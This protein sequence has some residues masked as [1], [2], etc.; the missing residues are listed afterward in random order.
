MPAKR[1]SPLW[2]AFTLVMMT[3]LACNLF[4][5]RPTPT[6]A[7]TPTPAVSPTP[8]P[9]IAPNIID[10]TPQRGDELAPNGAI[11]VYFDSPM[12]RSSVE[13]AFA[14]A[15]QVTGKFDWPDDSTL[16]FTPANPLE[17]ASRYTVTINADAKSRAGLTLPEAF[18]FKADTVGFLEVTQVI[19]APD[20]VGAEVNSAITVM[21]N[22]PVVPLTSLADQANLPNPLTLEPAV[23]GQGEWL[24]TS[25]FVFRPDQSLAGGQTYNGRVAAGLQDTTGGLLREDFTWQFTTLAPE[26]VGSEPIFGQQDFPLTQPISITFNQPMDR[27]STEAAFTLLPAAPGAFRWS[28]DGLTLGFVPGERLALG[29]EY[30]ARVE[31]SA[32]S[33]NGSAALVQAFSLSFRTVPAPAVLSTDPPD[34]AQ[35]ADYRNGFR[36][37]FA[38]PMDLG[39]LEPNI[40]I[41]PP[42]TQVYTY[43]SDFDKSFYLGWNLEP[44]TDYTVNLNPGMK[45][46][47]DNEVTEGRETVGFT[48]APLQPQAFFNSNGLVGT[49]NAY[50]DT[51]LYVTT[52]NVDRLDFNLYRLS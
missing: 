25:I 27:V 2:V 9:P 47:Y 29:T 10:F 26:V 35:S 45:D 32:K 21:F 16:V 14:M 36:I 31:S 33:A 20:T 17:R 23:N 50:T 49:Y 48:T 44:S 5:P 7:F 41:V 37:F 42:P 43:W 39:T 4:G 8:L 11:T 34:G 52:V 46:P 24:N 18:S 40:E 30:T 38:S 28:E 6:P 51:V 15:P 3:S 13:T 1:Q 12:D 22:R 19:P